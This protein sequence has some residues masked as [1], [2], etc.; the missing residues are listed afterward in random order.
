MSDTNISNKVPNVT[1]ASTSVMRSNIAM[2]NS[3]NKND[4]LR[5][6]TGSKPNMET[7][8]KYF[9]K[10]PQ[11]HRENLTYLVQ[12]LNKRRGTR[13]RLKNRQVF[14][15]LFSVEL[16]ERMFR[17]SFLKF[18]FF[19]R[20]YVWKTPTTVF[21][22]MTRDQAN[23][24]K[25]TAKP[26]SSHGLGDAQWFVLNRSSNEAE[27]GEWVRLY[28]SM[29]PA[30]LNGQ[31]RV[32]VGILP[33]ESRPYEYALL[34]DPNLADLSFC[35][36]LKLLNSLQDIMLTAEIDMEYKMPKRN[37]KKRR[38]NGSY[39]SD[40]DE[41]D[42]PP[43]ETPSPKKKKDAVMNQFAFISQ[44]NI[45]TT[46][47]V[48]FSLPEQPPNILAQGVLPSFADF[49]Q[50]F[51]AQTGKTNVQ[52]NDLS[53]ST[54]APQKQSELQSKQESKP[55]ANDIS[56]LIIAEKKISAE[57]E[58]P[59]Y[60]TFA[61]FFEL[62]LNSQSP[63]TPLGAQGMKAII[64]A[65]SE[66]KISTT[67]STPSDSLNSTNEEAK[68]PISSSSFPPIQQQKQV[69]EHQQASSKARSRFVKKERKKAGETA[70]SPLPSNA[71]LF[72]DTSYTENTQ[73]PLEN[74][75]N[76]SATNRSDTAVDMSM[77]F[78][79]GDKNRVATNCPISP[80]ISPSTPITPSSRS[81]SHL[82]DNQKM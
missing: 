49:A 52:Q 24:D 48:V 15:V 4:N 16:M 56:P 81:T 67:A 79:S 32:N 71:K 3:D 40:D 74:T 18:R 21:T 55:I 70:V 26:M 46:S 51:Q 61:K 66:S 14:C 27:R 41:E 68:S 34:P 37:I 28:E 72:I 60:S 7:Q 64:E 22:Q 45:D 77:T 33:R 38:V 39:I 62:D 80:R 20:G 1:V 10:L 69:Q 76:Q 58:L 53:P 73:S 17:G 29:P 54:Y 8:F 65:L 31:V 44:P 59:D 2:F 12:E 82:Y 63:V 35:Q 47:S 23:L 78:A 5:I 75:V 19:Y 13:V 6:I 36:P 25:S 42:D 30:V 43:P 9:S 50:F 11:S 57:D